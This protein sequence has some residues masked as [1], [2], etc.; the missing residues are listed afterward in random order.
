MFLAHQFGVAWGR[1]A[2]VLSHCLGK[3]MRE[4]RLVS[5]RNCL[6]ALAAFF[7]VS[8]PLLAAEGMRMRSLGEGTE[9]GASLSLA[10]M[11]R[12]NFF[13]QEASEVEVE[14]LVIAPALALQQNFKRSQLTLD[15]GAQFVRFDISGNDS[16]YIDSQFVGRFKYD[17]GVRSAFD[18]ELASVRG[19]DPFGSERTA[20]VTPNPDGTFPQRELDL[21]TRNDIGGSYRYGA[22]TALLNVEVEAKY[23]TKDYTTNESSTATLNYGKMGLNQTLFLNVSPKTA[24]VVQL[25]EDF[26]DY[27]NTSG[28]RDRDATELRAYGGFRWKA[29]TKTTGDL[30][31]GVTRRTLDDDSFRILD[32]F[33]WRGNITWEP[34]TRTSVSLESSRSSQEAIS[35]TVSV[36]DNRRTSISLAQGWTKSFRTVLSAGISNSRFI[37]TD[38]K[39]D[40]NRYAVSAIYNFRG[41]LAIYADLVQMDLDSN[42]GPANNPNTLD[43][44]ANTITVG[45]RVSP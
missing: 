21:W 36:V 26:V 43:F 37:G 42:Q 5:G 33:T 4:R 35:D 19:H 25:S 18:L 22:S 20:G 45:I 17:G 1:T 7:C 16:D 15:A 32:G 34:F 10:Q 24:V 3:V 11:T 41:A 40:L 14:G 28:G 6:L 13:Y 23:Q 44:T 8:E 31:L 2:V 27:E 30:R 29:T 38:R 9:V 39:D 12:D